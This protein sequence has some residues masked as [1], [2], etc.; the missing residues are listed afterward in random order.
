MVFVSSVGSEWSLVIFKNASSRIFN[1]LFQNFAWNKYQDYRFVVFKSQWGGRW[2]FPVSD[3]ASLQFA[4]N[5][6]RFNQW[7]FEC[8][9]VSVFFC[10]VHS[11]PETLTIFSF[12][13]PCISQFTLE[14]ILYKNENNNWKQN[15]FIRV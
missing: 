14:T 1:N 13:L 11:G 12:V 5:F 8:I 3:L 9:Q 6:Q 15:T 10:L 7:I 4:L 2:D